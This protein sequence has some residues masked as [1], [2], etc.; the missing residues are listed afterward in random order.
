MANT[1]RVMTLAEASA[2]RSGQQKRAHHT[3]PQ[4][5]ANGSPAL[6]PLI[7]K[8]VEGSWVI[9]P[10]KPVKG[11]PPIG[12]ALAKV[13]RLHP[14]AFVPEHATMATAMVNVDGQWH[15]FL[16]LEE[17]LYVRKVFAAHGEPS[18]GSM[19]CD[20]CYWRCPSR[21]MKSVMVGVSTTFMHEFHV[22]P[23]CIKEGVIL[24]TKRAGHQAREVDSS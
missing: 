5:W 18:P 11:N 3:K 16:I 15:K 6:S 20:A 17:K 1:A 4:A 12:R 2:P 13:K 8:R 9:E 7:A 23:D 19:P 10:W 21:K 22:C 24:A 14:K